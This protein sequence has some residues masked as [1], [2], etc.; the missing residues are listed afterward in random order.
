MF[1]E[2]DRKLT[3]KE[4][5]AWESEQDT[6]YEYENGS[7]IAITSGTLAQARIIANLSRV[8][9]QNKVL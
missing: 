4:Y 6:K 2:I 3:P 7:I 8:V 1:A 9:L 5:L